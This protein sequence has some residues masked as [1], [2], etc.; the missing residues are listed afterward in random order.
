MSPMSIVF[1]R[2]PM[3]SA[4]P[5]DWALGELAIPCERVTL[6]LAKGETRT[7][8]FLAINPNGK[9]PTLVVDGQPMWEGLA[10]I[11]WLGDRFGVEKGLWPA[12]SDPQRME[13]LTW[14]VWAYVSFGQIVSRLWLTTSERMPELRN[15]AMAEL[16]RKE[17]HAH[18]AILEARLEGRDWLLGHAFSLVDVVVGSM[19]IFA[20]F[21]GVS[22]EEFPRVKAWLARG[23]DRPASRT[24]G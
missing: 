10:I 5:V 19:L 6:D 22:F 15:A 21:A 18:L 17:A 24:I 12:A 2:A 7:P 11:Q 9:V 8:A 13:A 3:S 1:Y 4:S 16:C 20:E 14:S 23:K